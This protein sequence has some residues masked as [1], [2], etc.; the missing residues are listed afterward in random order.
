MSWDDVFRSSDSFAEAVCEVYS[1]KSDGQS[2]VWCD[3]E[4]QQQKQ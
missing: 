3:S 1:G 4:C 2:G